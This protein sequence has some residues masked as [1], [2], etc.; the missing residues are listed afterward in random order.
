MNAV[1]SVT[2]AHVRF[3]SSTAEK[4]INKDRKPDEP[5][6]F[7]GL[8]GL[9]NGFE[10]GEGREAMLRGLP[11]YLG[12]TPITPYLLIAAT[13]EASKLAE[14]IKRPDGP[15]LKHA[16]EEASN[17]CLTMDVPTLMELALDFF[18]KFSP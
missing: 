3:L 13:T 18:G 4:A 9:I 2:L 6:A 16:L 15:E 10:G 12:Q 7:D 1:E 8:M 14:Y 17:N 5:T 11:F